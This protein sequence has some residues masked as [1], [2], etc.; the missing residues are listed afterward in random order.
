[1]FKNINRKLMVATLLAATVV[2]APAVAFAQ[3]STGP[4]TVSDWSTAIVSFFT[5]NAP[6]I[7][8]AIIAVAGA[9]VVLAIGNNLVGR[10]WDSLASLGQRKPTGRKR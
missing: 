3:T 6:A 9:T 2:L 1:M 7:G 5:S 8:L 4:V 10:V